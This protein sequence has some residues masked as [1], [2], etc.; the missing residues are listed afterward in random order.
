G[1]GKPRSY[2]IGRQEATYKSLS[3]FCLGKQ[4]D[5]TAAD[6]HFIQRDAAGTQAVNVPPADIVGAS[7]IKSLVERY[8]VA[9]SVRHRKSEESPVGKNSVIGNRDIAS[10][11]CSSSQKPAVSQAVLA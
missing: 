3:D 9:V 1:V 5:F 2:P 8:G 10:V 11:I 6:R 4:L 7:G